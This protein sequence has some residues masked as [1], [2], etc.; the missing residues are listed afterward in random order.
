MNTGYRRQQ[1]QQAQSGS[2]D[3][4]W[5]LIFAMMAIILALAGLPWI[6]IGF[7][8]L[9]TWPASHAKPRTDGLRRCRQTLPA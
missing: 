2:N 7:V 4:G 3:P 6:M 5:M 1:Y 8:K 9:S